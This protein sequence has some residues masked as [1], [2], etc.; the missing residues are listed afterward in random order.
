VKKV[1]LIILLL[2]CA[3]LG[4]QSYRVKSVQEKLNATV[5]ELEGVKNQKPREIVI[6]DTKVEYKYLDGKTVI[7]ERVPE[8]YVKFDLFKYDK[9]VTMV[10][11]V[12]KERE[13]YVGKLNSLLSK[14]SGDSVA[15]GIYRTKIA[16]LDSVV[17]KFNTTIAD[18]NDFLIIKNRGFTFRPQIGLGYSGIVTP[19]AGIKFAFWNRYGF[20]VGSTKDQIGIGISRHI[21]DLVPYMKNTEIILLGGLPYKDGNNVFLGLCVGL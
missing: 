8:G 17:K 13:V 9:V 19:Y 2:L 1:L 6:T 3:A 12:V 10:D 21:D 18:K 4:I 5:I 7:K 11:S 16:H 20:S 15:I 14:A